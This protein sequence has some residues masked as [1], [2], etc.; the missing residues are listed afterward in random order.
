M[1]G[2]A[3][4]KSGVIFEKFMKGTIMLKRMVLGVAMFLVVTAT[5]AQSHVLVKGWNLVGNDAGT[6]VSP[7]LVFGNV[8][9]APS[10]LTV[11]TWDTVNFRWKFYTP[12]KTATDLAAYA[13]SKGYGVLTVIKAGE[14]FWVNTANVV[15]VS[16][17][18]PSSSSCVAPA[19]WSATAKVCVNPL[20]VQVRGANQLPDGCTTWTDQCWKDSA[21]G[22]VKFVATSALMAGINRPVM[23]SYFR[24]AAGLWAV[25]P[26]YGDDGS[27]FGGDISNGTP[28][29]IDWIDGTTSG[30]IFHMRGNNLCYGYQYDTARAE[31]EVTAPLPCPF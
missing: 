10:I 11:W 4:A 26:V 14:G 28:S 9:T 3:R 31:W 17:N 5:L 20:G 8:T 6:D 13:D 22:T 15:V 29:E 2:L 30:I 16:L 19:V 24:T 25:I 1:P 23:F 27:L 18:S 21:A 7:A 12:A